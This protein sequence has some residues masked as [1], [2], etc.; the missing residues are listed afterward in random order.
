[1]KD[2]TVPETAEIQALK[3]KPVTLEV[4]ITRGKTC[5]SWRLS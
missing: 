4:P 1:M 2:I 5:I 3:Q